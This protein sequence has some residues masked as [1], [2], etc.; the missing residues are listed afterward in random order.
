M[1]SSVTKPVPR[2]EW[3]LRSI[4]ARRLLAR[5]LF[6]PSLFLGDTREPLDYDSR[7]PG[8][9][10]TH[11]ESRSCAHDSSGG[12]LRREPRLHHPASSPR[13]WVSSA[14]VK[15]RSDRSLDRASLARAPGGRESSYARLRPVSAHRGFGLPVGALTGGGLA[16]LLQRLGAT[17]LQ[18]YGESYSSTPSQG[19]A[20]SG[21]SPG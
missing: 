13:S 5:P 17:P 8:W 14:R 12:G 2:R 16:Q 6:S 19:R 21:A 3:R 15:P 10:E 20:F 4:P 7:R 9:P 18:S 11:A 1:P